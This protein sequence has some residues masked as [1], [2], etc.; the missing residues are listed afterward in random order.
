MLQLL[1]RIL[2]PVQI[3]MKAVEVAIAMISG[4]Y[5]TSLISYFMHRDL[6]PSLMKVICLSKS[7]PES[8]SH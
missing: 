6:F 7:T 5:K 2:L 1:I 3:R 4:G 8:I